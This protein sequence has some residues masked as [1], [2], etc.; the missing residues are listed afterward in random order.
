MGSKKK[1]KKSNKKAKQ[2]ALLFGVAILFI[3]LATLGIL[4]FRN[5]KESKEAEAA[6]ENAVEMV[7]STVE[8]GP[9][10]EWLKKFEEPKEPEVEPEKPKDTVILFAGDVLFDYGMPQHYD[11]SGIAGVVGANLL[12][13]MNEA[14]VCVVNEEFPFGTAG[15]PA[16]KEY[17]FRCNPK[18][19]TALN[20]M[21]VDVV[22]L[23]NNHALDYGTDCLTQTF[24]TLEQAGIKFAGAGPTLDRAK[25]PQII[26]V[27]DKKI[28]IVAGS[29]VVPVASWG[30]STDRP[31]MLLCYETDQICESISKAKEQADYVFVFVHWGI[32]RNDFPESYE[33]S[34]AAKF[35]EAG[36]SAVIGS[37]PH[38][39]QGMEE[40]S[41]IPVFYSLGNYI[42]NVSIEKTMAV[43]CTISPEGLITW[44]VIPCQA[45]NGVTE[46][47]EP[48]K[49][50]EIWKHVQSLSTNAIINDQG[51]ISWIKTEE[52]SQ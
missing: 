21:G 35:A 1:K 12:A 22:S 9:P 41:G 30:A 36:A 37:H 3:A 33:K 29:R 7:E 24:A 19:V 43:T 27:N 49:A 28:A 44:R 47:A 31:G 4:A 23:A 17:T 32:E 20:E 52:A 39:L 8:D 2:T 11:E 15:S 26:E 6:N 48:E 50:A 40:V 25:E 46:V 16:E 38:V 42:F 10:E 5:Y 34:M 51:E 14:D 13:K 45:K 18:Y